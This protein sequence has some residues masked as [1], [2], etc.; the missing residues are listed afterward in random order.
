MI[1]TTP[2]AMT[3]SK[4]PMISK[5]KTYFVKSFRAML[6]PERKSVF[7]F[8]GRLEKAIKLMMPE[9]RPNKKAGQI[10]EIL[11]KKTADSFLKSKSIKTMTNK[12]MTAPA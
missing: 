4:I 3:S 5:I 8:E 9:L 1:A 6:V 11:L 7:L 2:M 10:H 12:T